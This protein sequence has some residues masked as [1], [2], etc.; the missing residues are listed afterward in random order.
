MTLLDEARQMLDGTIIPFWRNLRDNEYG[1][2]FGW[3]N[4]DLTVDQKAVKGCILNSRVLWFFSTAA[5]VLKSEADHAYT[6]LRNAFLDQEY[7]GVYWSV[8]YDGSVCDET[9]HTTIRH[10]LFTLS[11]LT[12]GCFRSGSTPGCL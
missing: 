5:L 4:F 11:P 8:N 7:G 9:K 6:F 2:Y 1:G 10:L 3:M 12:I